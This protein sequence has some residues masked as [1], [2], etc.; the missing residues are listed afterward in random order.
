M[1]EMAVTLAPAQLAFAGPFLT[2][3]SDLALTL[4][5]AEVMFAAE[6]KAEIAI[7]KLIQ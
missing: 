3:L 1:G 6:A 5:E 7:G 4:G 2:Y